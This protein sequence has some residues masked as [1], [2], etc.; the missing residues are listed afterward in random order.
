L[1]SFGTWAQESDQANDSDLLARLSYAN[2]AVVQSGGVQHVCGAVTPEGDYPLVRSTDYGQTLRLREKMPK[3]Y[4]CF[5]FEGKNPHF[6]RGGM[7]G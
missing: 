4:L 2:S 3:A 5:A 1:I 6:H 7:S